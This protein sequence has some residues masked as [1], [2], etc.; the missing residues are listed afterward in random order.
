MLR[1]LE[2]GTENCS[3]GRT[4]D[5][6][7]E[8]WTLLVLREA[9][10]G[11]RRFAD[12]QRHTGAPRPVLADRLR[13]LVGAGVLERVPYREP[14][15]RERLEYRLSE[16]GADLQPV[17]V[18]LMQWGDRH[19][20]DPEGPPVVLEHRGC[21]QPVSAVLAC[22]GCGEAPLPREEVRA[23]RGPGARPALAG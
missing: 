7:G 11:V 15:R 18:A 3:V 1:W 17:L 10:N 23:E 9:F 8:K 22:G 19:L 12:F 20:A 21:G 2:L 4:L 5:L 16:K 14:G 13:K 6:V